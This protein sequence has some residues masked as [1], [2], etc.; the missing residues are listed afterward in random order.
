MKHMKENKIQDKNVEKLSSW[1]ILIYRKTYSKNLSTSGS[2]K[3]NF[4]ILI[5]VTFS[6]KVIKYLIKQMVKIWVFS[7]LFSLPHPL[8]F[9]VR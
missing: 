8:I 6:P 9:S 2:G 1:K 4:Y 3:T 5:T 7:P